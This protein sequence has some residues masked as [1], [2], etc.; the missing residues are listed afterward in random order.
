MAAVPPI[1]AT[2]ETA[3][4]AHVRVQGFW[5]RWAFHSTTRRERCFHVHSSRSPR[6]CFAWSH[7]TLERR[8]AY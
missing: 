3:D 2:L 5:L 6:C 1:E 4:F 7:R 8:N